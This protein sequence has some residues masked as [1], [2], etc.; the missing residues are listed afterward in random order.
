VILVF[1]ADRE[2]IYK[3]EMAQSGELCSTRDS[4]ARRLLAE[5]AANYGIEVINMEPVFRTHFLKTGEHFDYLPV[6]GHWNGVA[7]RLAA[8]EVARYINNYDRAS[9][10]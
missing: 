1:D 10:H 7:H 6:D 2:A 5:E 4:L 8:K 9:V 3:P